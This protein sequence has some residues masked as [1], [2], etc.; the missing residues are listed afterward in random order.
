M[1]RGPRDL[2]V[3]VI[4][5]LELEVEEEVCAI[6]KRFRLVKLYEICRM[7]LTRLACYCSLFLCGFV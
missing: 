1:S 5:G 6:L 4:V 2:L 3:L 7:I